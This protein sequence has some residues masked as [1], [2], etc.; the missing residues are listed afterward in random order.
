[1]TPKQA[2]TVIA[3]LAQIRDLLMEERGKPPPNPPNPNPTGY[4]AVVV[5][6]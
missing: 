4:K 2:D 6:E 5:P 1:M 3:L